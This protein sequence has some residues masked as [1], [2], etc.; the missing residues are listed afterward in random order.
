MIDFNKRLDS[1]K[2]RRQGVDVR[3]AFESSGQNMFGFDS[4]S[5]EAYESLTESSSIKYVI[6]AMAPVESTSTKVSI[7]EGQRVADSLIKSLKACGIN[8]IS[9]LQGSVALDIHIKG[10][11]DVDMLIIESD[12]V[13]VELPRINPNTYRASSDSRTMEDIIKDLRLNSEVILPINFPVTDVDTSGNKSIAMNK[14]SLKR[15]VDIVPACW[16]NTRKY[17]ESYLEVD[18]GVKIYHKKNKEL[19]LNLPFT[20]IK[21]ISDKDAIYLGN[22]RNSIRLMKNMIADMPDYKKNVV[23]KL[24]SYDLAAIAYHMDEKLQV[25]YRMRLGLVEKIREHLNHLLLNPV[26]RKLLYVPDGS[27]AIFDCEEKS[28]ALKILESEFTALAEA[29]FKDLYPH[30]LFYSPSML[31][32]RSV[33]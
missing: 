32:N 2:T 3:L 7:Q 28:A 30:A 24:S 25:P 9:R 1:L 20:H 27:R 16:Y 26:Q 23:K 15:K 4:R 8:A 12:T 17:Q 18:R 19:M 14:G 10:H 13:L 22:L 21:L 11:S 5:K 31:L 6:G 29:V 33:A